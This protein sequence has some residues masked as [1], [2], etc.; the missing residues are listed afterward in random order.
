MGIIRKIAKGIFGSPSGVAN[1][2]DSESSMEVLAKAVTEKSVSTDTPPPIDFETE[3]KTLLKKK[4][5]G[6]YSTILSGDTGSANVSSKTI[7]GG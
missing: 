5:K 2:K 1:F 4:K 7:L 3:E 6:S